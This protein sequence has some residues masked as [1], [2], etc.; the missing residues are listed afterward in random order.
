MARAGILYS[1]VAKAAAQL[2]ADGKNPTVD[3]VREALGRTGSKSTITPLLKRWKTEHQSEIEQVEAGLPPSLL[4]AVKGL[5]QHMEDEFAQRL[6][7]ARQA[8]DDALC[9]AAERE[10]KLRTECGAARTTNAALTEDLAHTRQA[11]AQLQ[12]R[13]HA[14]SV[15]LAT[16]EA[17]NAGL[18]QRLADRAAEVDT[19]D[20]LLSQARAQ[21]EH[22]HEATAAQRAEERQ[23]YERRIARLEQDLA[24]A[25]RHVA[26]QQATIAH[27]TA[28]QE[29]SAQALRA[30]QAELAAA[31]TARDR[32][33]GRLED[34]T[35][36]KEHMITQLDAMRQQLADV[37]VE[38]AGKVRENEMLGEQLRRAD[39]RASQLAE[40]K[41]A[42]L[43]ERGALE[44]RVQASGQKASDFSG[45]VTTQPS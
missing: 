10:E 33:A 23:G 30:A 7:Q 3:G 11:L 35:A 24:G 42:W 1:D 43:Q 27:L 12:E 44:Q 37:R 29:R 17:E 32:L 18:Q 15:T 38:M 45:S 31:S 20:R 4:A 8:H 26:A 25:Q 28:E 14:Q 9:A 13:H 41:A 36:A 21:F 2:A 39:E 6:K 5:Y 22:Y 34:E 16:V 19:L 40:E